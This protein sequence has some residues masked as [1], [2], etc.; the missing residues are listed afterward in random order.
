VV[1]C[2]ARAGGAIAAGQIDRL[3]DLAGSIAEHLRDASTVALR[4]RLLVVPL[5]VC[6]Y[7]P[8]TSARMSDGSFLL[9]HCEITLAPSRAWAWAGDR[10]GGGPRAGR[11][12][13]SF[14]RVPLLLR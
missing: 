8:W 4:D 9:D 11:T 2:W 13:G 6:G 5:G 7:L 14:I 10:P 12:S 1:G 3:S